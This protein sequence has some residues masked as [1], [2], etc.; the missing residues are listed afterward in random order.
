MRVPTS[1]E[2]SG[3]ERLPIR[4]R[5]PDELRL[6]DMLI[7]MRRE[8]NDLHVVSGDPAISNKL[9]LVALMRNEIFLL[10]AF[11]HHYRRL[12][13]E[14][15]AI[16][17]DRSTDGSREYL[18]R[19]PDVVLL[20]SKSGRS[21][22]YNPSIPGKFRKLLPNFRI[23]HLWRAQ[24]L[25]MFGLDRWTVHVDLDE[26]L[27]LPNGMTFP[28]LIVR[29]E[30]RPTTDGLPRMVWGIML[31]VYPQDIRALASQAGEDR[32]NRSSAWYF[33]GVEHL[34]LR[35]DKS[36]KLVYAGARAR[37]Y[38][39]FGVT[40]LYREL[41]FSKRASWRRLLKAKLRIQP[42]KHNSLEKIVM[43]KWSKG[44]YLRSP[45][46]GN[47]KAS[48]TTLLPIQHFRFSGALYHRMRFALSEGC[49][50]MGSRDYRMLKELLMSM[51]KQEGSF[52]CQNSRRLV[53][54]Q[55]FVETRNA[56]GF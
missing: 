7:R 49:Y 35:R 17:N 52:L 27:W 29:L 48:E 24:L 38:R 13:I 51:E 21:Y 34:R 26:F 31:D 2:L 25:D 16:L 37:L 18:L 46:R 50:Y 20:E 47:L 42:E 56:I 22:G 14:R 39:A 43:L 36:P 45:H 28:E 3:L 23:A 19:Q 40:P 44:S 9:T 33:D 55:D 30:S 32:L 54:F 11:L 15:F 12:G 8:L 10:P 53:S 6:G 1:I 4:H 5:R 41:G